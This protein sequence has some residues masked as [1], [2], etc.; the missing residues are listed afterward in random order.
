[1]F[2]LC[3]I[4]SQF[5]YTQQT[6]TRIHLLEQ[7]QQRL[8]QN[9]TTDEHAKGKRGWSQVVEQRAE[10]NCKQDQHKIYIREI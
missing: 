9:V 2:M 8:H 6:S 7:Q 3:L 5:K 1:M 10:K 4:Y